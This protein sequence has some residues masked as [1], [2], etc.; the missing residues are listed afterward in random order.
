MSINVNST[1]SVK[2]DV[3][4]QN[5]SNALKATDKSVVVA[6]ESLKASHSFKSNKESAVTDNPF[7]TNNEGRKVLKPLGKGNGQNFYFLYTLDKTFDKIAMRTP[8]KLMVQDD[9]ARL[10]AKG[11]T[12][13]VDNKATNDDFKNAFY[14]Q[15]AV[16]VVSLG[17]GGEGTLVTVA[18]NGDPE[19]DY[20][21]HWDI[22]TKK[23][24]PNLKMV[25][26]QACQAGMEEKSW[27]KALNTDV[28]AW[29]KSVSNLEVMSS[30]A[31][32][33]TAGIFPVVG[34]YFSIQSQLHSKSL[35]DLI[36]TRY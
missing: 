20:L 23:V 3:P 30:N 9:I 16:G 14:D 2:T 7:D 10:R 19:G 28:I 33:A 21:T 12:V 13:I 32:I 31:H 27:E 4:V 26:L 15:K 25:Y 1:N 6:P 17:H 5:S 22:E 24:S 34:A 18:K 36:K 35:A 29:T 8:N 11:Y